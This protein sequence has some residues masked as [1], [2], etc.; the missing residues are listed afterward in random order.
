MTLSDVAL[1]GKKILVG[2]IVTVVPFI[3]I[4]GGLWLGQKLL[5]DHPSAKQAVVKPIKPAAS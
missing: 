4:A 2:V 1:L 3:I 5:T